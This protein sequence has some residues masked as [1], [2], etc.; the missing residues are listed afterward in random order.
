MLKKLLPALLLIVMWTGVAQALSLRVGDYQMEWAILHSPVSSDLPDLEAGTISIRVQSAAGSGACPPTSAYVVFDAPASRVMG[1]TTTWCIRSDGSFENTPPGPTTGSWF[2]YTDTVAIIEVE[3]GSKSND[4][5]MAVARFQEVGTLK[6]FITQ[7]RAGETVSGTVWVVMWVDGTS[8]T[9]NVF[10]VSVN[11]TPVI[12]QNAGSSHGPVTLPW[13]SQSVAN[14]V[15]TIG[16]EV[17][18]ATGNSGKTS[19]T[20]TVANP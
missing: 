18:D 6:V 5:V 3:Q 19:I 17:R 12:S 8:G 9:S 15:H 20:V 11:G 7:P 1:G 10:T 4:K 2:Q 13:N 14:G 16:A